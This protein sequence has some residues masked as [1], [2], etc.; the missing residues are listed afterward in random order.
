MKIL[1]LENP[2][3]IRVVAILKQKLEVYLWKDDKE[4]AKV[5]PSKKVAKKKK[6]EKIWK[7]NTFSYAYQQDHMKNYLIHSSE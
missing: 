4:M 2:R 5:L 3:F 1:F 7:Y 6:K